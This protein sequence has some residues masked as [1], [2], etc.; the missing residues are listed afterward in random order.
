MSARAM[1]QLSTVTHRRHQWKHKA[2][3]RGDCARYQRKPRARLTAERDRAIHALQAAQARLR[4]SESH[5]QAGG[6]AAEG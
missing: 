4:Q 6:R 1:R 5:A 2:K 3:Q